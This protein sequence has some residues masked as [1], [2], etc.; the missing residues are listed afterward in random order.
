[1]AIFMD[2]GIKLNVSSWVVSETVDNCLMRVLSVY[3]A[4]PLKQ[5][6][7]KNQ[8]AITL[9]TI[10]NL[11]VQIMYEQMHFIPLLKLSLTTILK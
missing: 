9:R 11:K 4:C 3:C 1:M 10:T 7:S 2:P 6:K 5:K 8:A